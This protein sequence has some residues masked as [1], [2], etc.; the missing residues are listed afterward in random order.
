MF[1]IDNGCSCRWTIIICNTCHWYLYR[2]NYYLLRMLGP[3]LSPWRKYKELLYQDITADAYW[4][5]H[6][7]PSRNCCARAFSAMPMFGQTY[8]A[9]TAYDVLGMLDFGSQMSKIKV[10]G[11]DSMTHSACVHD[12]STRSEWP[13][14][15]ATEWFLFVTLLCPEPHIKLTLSVPRLCHSEFYTGYSDWYLMLYPSTQATPFTVV[16]QWIMQ[17]E[18]AISLCCLLHGEKQLNRNIYSVTY[19]I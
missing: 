8:K 3:T 11:S 1:T 5:A 14:V 16:L 15:K 13:K 17:V 2:I 6:F 9:D 4:L 10:T 18:A 19:G 12:F 7:R